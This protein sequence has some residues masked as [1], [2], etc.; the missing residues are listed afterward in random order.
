MM[1]NTR[2]LRLNTICC[3]LVIGT[4]TAQVSKETLESIT[5]PDK[6]GCNHYFPRITDMH[7]ERNC[8]NPLPAIGVFN[9]PTDNALDFFNLVQEKPFAPKLQTL[10]FS[11]T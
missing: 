5:T 2:F 11:H 7:S 3:L 6:T 1:L 10:L 9:Q 8:I 4:A